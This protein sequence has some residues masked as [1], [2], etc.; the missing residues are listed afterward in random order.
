[1]FISYDLHTDKGGH[2]CWWKAQCKSQQGNPT[3]VGIGGAG[4]NGLLECHIHKDLS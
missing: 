3:A 4:R 2:T 1:M